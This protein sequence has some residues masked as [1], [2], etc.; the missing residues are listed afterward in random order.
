MPEELLAGIAKPNTLGDAEEKETPDDSQ[1]ENKPDKEEPSH[2]GDEDKS[3]D[4]S[5][6]TED[7]KKSEDDKDKSED[8]SNTDDEDDKKSNIPFHKHPRFK[9]IIDDNKKLKETIDGLTSKQDETDKKLSKDNETIPNWFSE[10][11]GDNE[12]A[13]EMY[14]DRTKTERKEMKA[15]ILSE[16]KEEQSKATEETNKWN[17]WVDDEIQSLKDEGLKFDKNELMKV[18]VDYKPTDDKGN[19]DLKKAYDILQMQLVKPK[20]NERKKVA[21][22]TTKQTK[23][24]SK[25]DEFQTAHSLRNKGWH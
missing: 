20:S 12:K 3:E 19:L 14:N 25:S 16:I 2:Q 17:E 5:E 18:A 4:E 8:K 7:D 15:E 1:S 10:L 21:D 22:G 9:Q 6:N 11:Y 23:S 13:W 24:E